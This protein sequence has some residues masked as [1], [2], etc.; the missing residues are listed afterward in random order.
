[1]T[2]L[3]GVRPHRKMQ[4]ELTT[5]GSSKNWGLAPRAEIGDQSR[6]WRPEPRLPTRA[7]I[8]DH[9]GG[10]GSGRPQGSPLPYTPSLIPAVATDQSPPSYLN[11]SSILTR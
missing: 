3:A 8:D 5:S 6:D 4:T 7:G 2:P 1:M 11:E 10:M 9:G